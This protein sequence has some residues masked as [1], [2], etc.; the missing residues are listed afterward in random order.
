MPR[1]APAFFNS[2]NGLIEDIHV[3]GC[4]RNQISQIAGEDIN[5]NN[6]TFGP[7]EGVLP[8]ACIDFEADRA[9][10][11]NR[12]VSINDVKGNNVRAGIVFQGVKSR[13]E[14]AT[15]SNVHL[16]GVAKNNGVTANNSEAVSYT[17][18][19]LPT[20]PYV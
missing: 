5:Y 14:Q 16:S 1:A 19:T 8:G 17:H 15:L 10:D 13:I 2:Y 7:S 11:I 20:T 18:L 4:R 9:V 3:E 6:L 12:R